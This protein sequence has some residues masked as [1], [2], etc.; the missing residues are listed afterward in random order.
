MVPWGFFWKLDIENQV[1]VCLEICHPLSQLMLIKFPYFKIPFGCSHNP[2]V[3]H[4]LIHDRPLSFLRVVLCISVSMI[5][6]SVWHRI[7]VLHL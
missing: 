4:E 2:E 3:K 1:Y 7:N 6:N 5:L